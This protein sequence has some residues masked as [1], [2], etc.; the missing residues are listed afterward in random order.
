MGSGKR[1]GATLGIQWGSRGSL[2]GGGDWGIARITYGIAMKTQ[3][4]GKKQCSNR[5]NVGKKTSLLSEM[6]LN[7]YSQ[8]I[9]ERINKH[10][11]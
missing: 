6:N 10:V 3:G 7:A 11:D 1:W 4:K 9:R 2:E 5:W 8:S